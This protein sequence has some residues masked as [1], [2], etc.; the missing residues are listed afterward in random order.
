MASV[1]LSDNQFPYGTQKELPNHGAF[2]TAI[3]C[4]N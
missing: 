2:R 3:H 1:I 4:Q